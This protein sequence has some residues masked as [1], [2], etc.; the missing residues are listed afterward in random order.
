MPESGA[1]SV[2]AH[3]YACM[4]ARVSCNM[5]TVCRVIRVAR[6]F[7]NRHVRTALP[8]ILIISQLVANSVTETVVLFSC[9]CPR[10]SS[11]ILSARAESTHKGDN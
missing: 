5:R 1:R 6:A 9:V 4:R 7:V 10:A 2:G 8:V 3:V 11:A